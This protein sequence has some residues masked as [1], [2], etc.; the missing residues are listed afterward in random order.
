MIP[1]TNPPRVTPGAGHRGWLPAL[2]LCGASVVAVTGHGAAPAS[3]T[4]TAAECADLVKQ[5]DVAAPAHHGAP[6]ADDAARERA[7]GDQA[8]QAGRYADGVESLRKA[9]H[10]IGVS[11][12]RISPVPHS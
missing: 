11:P 8:C 6:H 7:A 2:L 1:A 10:H 3:G 4:H 5:Y 9:L 12:V